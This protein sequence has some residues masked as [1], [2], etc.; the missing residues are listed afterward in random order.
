MIVLCIVWGIE[1]M[2]EASRNSRDKFHR[3]F[4]LHAR[5]FRNTSQIIDLFTDDEGRVSVVAR[6]ATRGGARGR[7]PLSVQLQPFAL[8]QVS[9]SGR[10]E[11]YTLNRTEVVGRSYSLQGRRTLCGLYA[12]ELLVRL[13]HRGDPHVKL[14]EQ[15]GE[16]LHSLDSGGDEA[17]LL[18][19]FEVQLL[20]AVGFG[21]DLQIDCAGVPIHSDQVYSYHPEEGMMP[22]SSSNEKAVTVMGKTLEWLRTTE[23]KVEK[24]V[25]QEAKYLL[26]SAIDYHLPNDMLESRKLIAQYGALN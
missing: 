4:V 11:L 23:S 25:M 1:R 19:A 18:R 16:L 22:F 2:A 24:R 5:P 10:G 26:R 14:F 20:N 17:C 6:G 3:A 9:W 15:Y 13:L 7:S 12:N 21:F 8:L